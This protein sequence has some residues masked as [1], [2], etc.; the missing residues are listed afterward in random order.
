MTFAT[1]C[2]RAS[3][4]SLRMGRRDFIAGSA[5]L[6]VVATTPLAGRAQSLRLRGLEE[7]IRDKAQRDHIPGV[8]ACLI[9]GDE[10]AWSHAYG[11]AD[12][13]Q[14][15]AMSLDS[16]Q[17]IASISKTFAATAI[18]QLREAGLID[19][20][21]DVNEYLAFT[22][23]NPY[24]LGVPISARQLLTHTSS[25]RDGPAYPQHYACGDPKMSLG[26]WVREYL[27]VGG[28]FY[29]EANNFLGR[30]PGMQWSYCN[31]AY[32]LLG[33]LVEAVSGIAYPEYCRRNIFAHLEM[34]DTSW[35]L[36]DIDRRRHAVP[37]TWA[38][39][40]QARGRSWD[41]GPMG[42]VQMDGRTRDRPLEDGFHPNCLYNHPNYPDGFLRT[43]V[44][45]LS[46]YLR[47]YLGGGAFAGQRILQPETVQD[48]LDVKLE[49]PTRR[50]GLTWNVNYSVDGEPA[51]GHSGQDPG[52]NTDMRIL[53]A[54]N[55]GAIAFAN[56]NNIAP[57]EFT[58]R[59]LE[60]AL[61][62]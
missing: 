14:R 55:L 52:V 58:R 46:R 11:F 5:A 27:T 4:S 33:H 31:I 51:W 38:S 12:L 41:D 18:M 29:D 32:G 2:R 1:D 39:G 9:E 16:L 19:L 60:T 53:P 42:A 17:N 43:S 50:Q 49:A 7:F 59:I 22:V 48:M 10:I 34:N 25:L 47:A 36:A 24:Y 37:Y 61:L 54:R 13:E 6:S 8:A 3:A 40:G 20:D 21:A 62:L 35:L 28:R 23:R 56:T 57:F 45:D 30:S 15:V 26:T 44:N